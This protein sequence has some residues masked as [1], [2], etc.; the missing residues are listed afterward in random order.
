MLTV[1]S[2]VVVGEHGRLL[3]VALHRHQH[4]APLGFDLVL[5]RVGIR[6]GKTTHQRRRSLNSTQFDVVHCVSWHFTS[7][8]EKN[9]GVL[10]SLEGT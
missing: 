2:D 9:I 7:E 4:G 3:A 6:A 1:E 10:I 5:L 8:I